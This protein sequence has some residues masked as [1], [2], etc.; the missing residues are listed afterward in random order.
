LDRLAQG[1][2]LRGLKTLNGERIIKPALAGSLGGGSQTVYI[3][4]TGRKIPVGW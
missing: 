1:A 2:H 4:E 3:T